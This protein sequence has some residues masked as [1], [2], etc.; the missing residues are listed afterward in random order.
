MKKPLMMAMCRA[1]IGLQ[2]FMVGTAA[3]LICSA[4]TAQDF[5]SVS[6]NAAILYDAPSIKAKKLFVAPKG[7]PVQV[8]TVVEPFVKVRDMTGDTAWLDRRALGSA[9][10]AITLT[11]ATV[12]ASSADSAAAIAQLER[13]VV[14]EVLE[15]AANGWIKV[16]HVDASSGFVKQSEVW[17]N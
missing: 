4:A 13:G 5:H 3:L 1:K 16:K 14:V 10:T 9:R 11:S 7:M 17:G 6:I 15:S 2:P 12:R 8:I